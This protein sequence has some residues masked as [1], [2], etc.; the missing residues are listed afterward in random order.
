MLILSMDVFHLS[1]FFNTKNNAK[2]FSLR[3]LVYSSILNS[4]NFLSYVF[5]VLRSLSVLW[6]LQMMQYRNQS[7]I[8]PPPHPLPYYKKVMHQASN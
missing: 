3:H 7:L 1:L 4:N 5:Q 6:L 8:T 2:W